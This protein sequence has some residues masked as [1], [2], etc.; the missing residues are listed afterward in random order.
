LIFLPSGV[1]IASRAANAVHFILKEEQQMSHQI[2]GECISCGSC[3]ASCPTE[4]ISEGKEHYEIDPEK[5]VDC[6]SCAESCPVSAI[7]K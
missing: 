2:T 1:K 4:A 5:C 7:E 6:G 3:S